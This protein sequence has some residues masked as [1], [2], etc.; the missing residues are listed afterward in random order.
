MQTEFRKEGESA[1]KTDT[2]RWTLTPVPIHPSLDKQDG[3]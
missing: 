1:V 3:Q 2:P